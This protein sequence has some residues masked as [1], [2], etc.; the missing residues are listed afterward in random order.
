MT[1]HRLLAEALLIVHAGFIGFVVF[2]QIAIMVGVALKQSWARNLWL[3]AAHLGAIGFVVVQAWLGIHCPLTI[4]EA[5][6]RW[7]AGQDIYAG[8]LEDI[9]FIAYWLH[10]MIFFDADPWVFTVIYSLF[11]LLVVTTFIFAPPRWKRG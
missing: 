2:G 1:I 9:G 4:W 8:R 11:G 6:L 5:E 10:R 3:R 7:R